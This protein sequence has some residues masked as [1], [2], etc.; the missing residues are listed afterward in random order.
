MQF[1]EF[2]IGDVDHL[3]AT[4]VNFRKATSVIKDSPTK[5]MVVWSGTSDLSFEPDL[6]DKIIKKFGL[7]MTERILVAD[8]EE[9]EI[10]KKDDIL[11]D[12]DQ[13]EKEKE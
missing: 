2:K 9:I 11:E 8:S 3:I 5:A 6:G 10:E 12:T 4:D 1:K 13:D 7:K